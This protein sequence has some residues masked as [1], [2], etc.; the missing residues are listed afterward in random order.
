MPFALND[1]AGEW[2]L[3]IRD[4]LSGLTAEVRMTYSPQTG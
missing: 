4:V 3:T 2:T 1:P